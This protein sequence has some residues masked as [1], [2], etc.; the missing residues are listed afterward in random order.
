MKFSLRILTLLIN[1][2]GC[3]DRE[4]YNF[5]E[6]ITNVQDKFDAKHFKPHV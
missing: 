4:N 5:M 3:D 2:M 1:I 6:N